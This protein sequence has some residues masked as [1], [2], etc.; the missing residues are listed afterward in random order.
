MIKCCIFDLDGTLLDTIGTIAHYVNI[1]LQKYNISPISI[2]ETKLFVGDGARELIARALRSR[3][4]YRSEE[5]CERVHSE[6]KAAY[7]A[8]PLYLTRVYPGIYELIEEL[9][10]RGVR[11]G[12]LSNKPMSAAVSV[13][14]HFFPNV[15][16][17]VLG[18]GEGVPLKPDPEGVYRAL[19]QMKFTPEELIYVGDTSTDMQPGIAAGASLTV[20][21]LWGFRDKE[22]LVRF[23]ADLTVSEPHELLGAVK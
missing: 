23:G 3:G 1:T 14:G 7:D 6:Y 2:E 17:V 5:F 19:R 4:E 10:A 15:F 9:R 22:E 8:E 21:V 11:L 20:G 18:A 16:D 13:V 12:V